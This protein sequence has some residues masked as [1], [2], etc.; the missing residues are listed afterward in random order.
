MFKQIYIGLLLITLTL[1]YCI[2][3]ED[4]FENECCVNHVCVECNNLR[5][6]RNVPNGCS[7]CLGICVCIG[8]NCICMPINK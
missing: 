6:K 7:G 1:G 5:L 4:C 3:D 2:H 8:E